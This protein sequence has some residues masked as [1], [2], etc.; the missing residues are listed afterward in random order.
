MP[1]KL[2]TP[3]SL[4]SSGQT[5]PRPLA[6]I[7]NDAATYDPLA[8]SIAALKDNPLKFESYDSVETKRRWKIVRTDT[9]VDVEGEIIA[10]DEMSGEC[11]LQIGEEAQS[12]SFGPRGIRIVGRRR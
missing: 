5:E 11:C 6:P 4:A 9:Y 1:L 10:A 2:S 3:G 8:A 7:S 12:L